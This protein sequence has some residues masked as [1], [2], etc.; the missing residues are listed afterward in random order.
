MGAIMKAPSEPITDRW[1][2]AMAQWLESLNREESEADV[3]VFRSY[4]DALREFL[5]RLLSEVAPRDAWEPF[6]SGA[7]VILRSKKLAHDFSVEVDD[8]ADTIRLASSVAY[9]QHLP[10]MTD[11][12]WRTV[13]QLHDHGTVNFSSNTCST[14]SKSIFWQIMED[15]SALA[16]ASPEDIRENPFIDAG[17]LEISWPL[18]KGIGPIYA[19][20]LAAFR[21]LYHLNYLLYRHE[22]IIQAARRKGCQS[23]QYYART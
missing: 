2:A 8:C 17:T 20:A 21:G 22:Y 5:E 19:N 23:R 13:L 15:H 12:F 6:F 11:E 14:K 4:L 3:D 16:I 10:K 9:F 7:T 1:N 18:S